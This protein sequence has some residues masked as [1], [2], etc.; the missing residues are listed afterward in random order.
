M[1]IT[2]IRNTQ[3]INMAVIETETSEFQFGFGIGIG[4]E[5]HTLLDR[6]IFAY[7]S[8]ID[9]VGV[10]CQTAIKYA[11]GVSTLSSPRIASP[12]ES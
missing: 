10:K 1:I 9:R 11:F 12:R 3:L 4:I 2:Q 8:K 5:T 7:R 6:Q